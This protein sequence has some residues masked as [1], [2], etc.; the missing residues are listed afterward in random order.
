MRFSR[1]SGG[2][3]GAVIQAFHRWRFSGLGCTPS[4]SPVRRGEFDVFRR[5]GERGHE[6]RALWLL[7]E[8]A[9]RG[10]P[11]EAADAEATYAEVSALYE[12]LGMRPLRALRDGSGA[13]ARPDGP[14]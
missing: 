10:E 8:V 5:Q 1:R 12:A 2:E 9:A 7:A 4:G 13:P 6:A 11:H 3:P 14:A